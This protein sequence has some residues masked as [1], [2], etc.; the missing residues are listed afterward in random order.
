MSTTH[1]RIAM[2]PEE[3][4]RQRLFRVLDLP[5][6][7]EGFELLDHNALKQLTP[8][9][10]GKDAELVV[11]AEWAWSPMHSR[12]SNWEI[13]LDDSGQYWVLWC[14]SRSDEVELADPEN[15]ADEDEDERAWIA[16]WDSELVAA[17]AKGKL[18]IEEV[19]ALLLL[20]A[21]TEDRMMNELDPPHFYGATGVLDIDVLRTVERAVWPE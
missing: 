13:D 2:S 18:E 17:C 19:T 14:S 9:E 1:N 21:W 7:P 8:K 11:Q 15:A 5:E 4:P 6:P 10:P 12:I 16:I 3:L 20:H